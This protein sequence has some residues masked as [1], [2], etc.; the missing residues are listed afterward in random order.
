MH[1]FPIPQLGRQLTVGMSAQGSLV[2]VEARPGTTDSRCQP[3]NN[4]WHPSA[5][6][7]YFPRMTTAPE[8]PPANRPPP[9]TSPKKFLTM[10]EGFP[11]VEAVAVR[12]GRVQAVGTLSEV[13]EAL[14]NGTSS[15]MR[16]SPMT[17]YAPA[18]STN[19]CTRSSVQP[20]SSQRSSLS[21]SGTCRAGPSLPRR[22][23]RST[24]RGWQQ[25][26]PLCR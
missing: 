21:N 14:G 19:T 7:C 25:R 13:T 2:P 4:A 17:S 3:T 11:E 9:S 23:R 5:F 6:R 8:A 24:A 20:H 22:L 12:D 10:E 16:R 18:S 26:R 1:G 15:S